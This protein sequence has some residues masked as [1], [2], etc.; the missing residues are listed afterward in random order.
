MEQFNSGNRW[1][2]LAKKA[3]NLRVIALTQGKYQT[4]INLANHADCCRDMAAT[5]QPEIIIVEQR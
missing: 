3:E 1:L 5:G 2:A 4:A